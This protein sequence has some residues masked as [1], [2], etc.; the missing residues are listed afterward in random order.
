MG[1]EPPETATPEP[2][3]ELTVPD[4]GDSADELDEL[5]ELVVGVGVEVAVGVDGWV[6]PGMVAA[7]T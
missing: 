1:Y 3:D 2:E 7:L 6:E 4:G 5:V